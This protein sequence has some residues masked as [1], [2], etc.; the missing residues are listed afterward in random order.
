M[1]ELEYEGGTVSID[2]LPLSRRGLIGVLG[3]GAASVA[4]GARALDAFGAGDA[5]VSTCVLTPEVTEGPYWIDNKLT[6]HD[7]REDK[8]G[9]PLVL[10]FTILNAKTCRPIKNADVE[11]WHADASGEYSGFDGGSSAGGPGSGSGPQTKTRYLRGHQRSD[12]LGKASFLTIFPGWYR[13]RTPHVHMKVHVGS[14]DRVVHTGQVFFDE[15]IEAS[16]YRTGAYA[17]RGQPDTSHAQDMIFAQAGGS[18]AVVR[19]GRRPGAARG[20]L[21]KIMIGVATT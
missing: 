4:F 5:N 10:Q 7:I 8:H 13:G 1:K 14:A 19:L 11:I 18:R 17:S 9:L 16:V 2:D 20:Y 21:G 6:R 15:A 12:A 3:G